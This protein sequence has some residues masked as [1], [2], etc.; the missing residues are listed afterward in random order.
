MQKK[1]KESRKS[2]KCACGNPLGS[3]KLA[4]SEC[5]RDFIYTIKRFRSY[6]EAQY[7]G[8]LEYVKTKGIGPVGQCVLCGGNYIFNGHNPAP[9]V[10]D[11][12]A[13][14]CR[15]C[16]E[17][18]VLPTRFKLFAEFAARQDENLEVNM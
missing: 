12:G 14:C 15:V 9:V 1:F 8:I 10:K 11:D 16:N 18:V 7:E 2:G 17:S 3:R 6:S 4:C 5:N 13:R